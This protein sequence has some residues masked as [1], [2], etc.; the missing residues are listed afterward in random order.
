VIL[1]FSLVND[2]STFEVMKW[3]NHLGHFDVLRINSNEANVIS[4]N[5]RN[6]DFSL[7]VNGTSIALSDIGAVWYRKGFNW[8]GGQFAEVSIDDHPR[9]T[10]YLNNTARK[11]SN[12]LS[13]Y[14][15]YLIEQ[16]VPVLGSAFKYDLNKLI[17]LNLAR[18]VGFKTPECHVINERQSAAQ[19]LEGGH[20]YITKAM[21]D[22]VYLFDSEKERK[23]YF[24]YTESLEVD[25]LASYP[26]RISPSF[27][28]SKIRKKYELRVFYLDG[29]F[30]SWAIISQS[31][32]Q[33]STDYRKYDAR[34]P[35]RVVPYSLP[36]NVEQKLLDLF[37]K[38]GLN[39]G[40]VDLMVDS[41]DDYYFLEINPVGQFGAL[42]K[43]TNYQLEL[44]IAKWLIE[45]AK[46]R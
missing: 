5:L 40:S 30:F 25:S 35:N 17:T 9:L 23:G 45:H 19:L 22:G 37:R 15:H 11:E 32:A 18:T 14:V 10:A 31:S 39:T 27:L 8:F 29:R 46:P 26:D 1:I 2:Y 4:F 34:K 3:L 24:S 21:S 42:S 36:E 13:E 44:E 28:Q 16:T 33:T 41:E 38:I 20:E 12:K 43:S 7:R 6:G